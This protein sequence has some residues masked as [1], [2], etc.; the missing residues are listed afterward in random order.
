MGISQKRQKTG[1]LYSNYSIDSKN[2]KLD[3]INDISS[4]NSKNFFENY[5]NIRKPVKFDIPDSQQIISIDKFK[6]DHLLDTLKFKDEVQ[7][8]KKFNSG[9]GSGQE[10]IKMKLEDL[11]KEIKNGSDEYYKTTQYDFDEPDQ[12]E[13]ADYRIKDLFQAPLTNLINHP[14]ILPIKPSFFN[15][16]PQQI[17]IWLGSSGS[18]KTCSKFTIDSSKP[19]LGLGKK[20]PGKIHGS[21]SGLH[22]DHADN[23]YVLIQGKKRF[24]IYS[25][26]DAFKLYTVGKIYQ[27]YNSGII[28][29][30]VDENSPFWK[31]V[32]DD[33][34]IIEEIIHWKLENLKDDENEEK[35]KLIAE[36]QSYIKQRKQVKKS[37]TKKKLDPPSFSKIP[38]ALLHLNEITN[39]EDLSK[40]KKFA[41]EKFPGFLELN[42][43]EI[44]LDKP[45]QMLYLPAGWFHEVSSFGNEKYDDQGV[46]IAI[47][48]WF[49]PPNKNQVDNCY[50]DDYWTE[51][52]KKTESAIKLIK[53]E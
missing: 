29:Y 19:D 39:N 50:Q 34:A 53:E 48:Y 22:H 30:E 17:N 46:H 35:S 2:E 49:I 41:D 37:T 31:H 14:D 44:W 5:I 3:V 36:L 8:E 1:N 6:L 26:K 43:I 18:K 27:I 28:D 20:L 38:P 13:E 16:I 9:F 47:N 23:L 21:S 10:R 12:E 52:W 42:K 11:I 7:V 51:D 40:L 33:G 45:G 32:R 15:L 25:P 24:T 4:I